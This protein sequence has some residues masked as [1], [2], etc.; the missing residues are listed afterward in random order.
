MEMTDRKRESPPKG[1]YY[2]SPEALSGL[3]KVFATHPD[4]RR[5]VKDLAMDLKRSLIAT[6]EAKSTVAALLGSLDFKEAFKDMEPMC[7]GAAKELGHVIHEKYTEKAKQ[8]I[9][10]TLA[11]F[12]ADKAIEKEIEDLTALCNK[13]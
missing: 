6:R 2:L 8:M 1:E 7:I 11:S 5:R 4:E 12:G 9:A 13:L 3:A 10:D